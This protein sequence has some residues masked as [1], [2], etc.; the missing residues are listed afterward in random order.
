MDQTKRRGIT[1]WKGVSAQAPLQHR[2]YPRHHWM[3]E[4]VGSFVE[5]LEAWLVAST[6]QDDFLEMRLA[7][8]Y[9]RQTFW[10]LKLYSKKISRPSRSIFTGPNSSSIVTID[11]LDNPRRDCQLNPLLADWRDEN[12]ITQLPPPSFSF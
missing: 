11:L 5:W 8:C 1:L 7:W 6:T 9:F 3:V 2:K 12:S 10:L 4:P